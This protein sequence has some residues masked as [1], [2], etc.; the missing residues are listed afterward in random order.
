MEPNT[1][2][3]TSPKNW[4]RYAAKHVTAWYAPCAVI[5]GVSAIGLYFDGE[6][7]WSCAA[8]AAICLICIAAIIAAWYRRLRLLPEGLEVRK[9]RGSK[10][11]P[12][13]SIYSFTVEGWGG[14]WIYDDWGPRHIKTITVELR[15]NTVPISLAYAF[16]PREQVRAFALELGERTGRNFADRVEPQPRSRVVRMLEKLWV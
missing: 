16:M 12:Y 6:S 14:G 8:L 4:A 1:A 3:G 5:V 10:I 13:P 7:I 15:H 2:S 11:L 9:L